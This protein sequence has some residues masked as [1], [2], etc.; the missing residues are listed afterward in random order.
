M[1]ISSGKIFESQQQIFP[2]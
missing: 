2:S 1:Y